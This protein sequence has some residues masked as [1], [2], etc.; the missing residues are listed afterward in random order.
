MILSLYYA[1]NLL[2]NFL[3]FTSSHLYVK[4]EMRPFLVVISL[5]NLRYALLVSHLRIRN[6]GKACDPGGEMLKLHK[7]MIM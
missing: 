7:K 4:Y 5:L 2:L 3:P 6:L 1:K